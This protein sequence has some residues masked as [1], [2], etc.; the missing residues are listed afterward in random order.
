M[1]ED[2][3]KLLKH[4]R[5]MREEM[6]AAMEGLTEDQMTEPTIDGWS[7]KDHLAHIAAWD[8]VRA[9][10]VERISAGHASAWK[11]TDEQDEAYNDMAFDLRKD[12]SVA[13]VLWELQSSRAKLLAAI[14]AAGERGLDA[15]LYGE[16]GLVS[17]HESE[18]AGWVRRWRGEKGY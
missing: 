6:L 16:A 15:S 2:R 13:Q 10:E 14:G 5:D 1:A 9:A 12:L 7:V 17:H 11:M 8:E 3:E 18:H 4:F